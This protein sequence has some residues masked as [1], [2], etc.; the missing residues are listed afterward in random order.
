MIGSQRGREFPISAHG[1]SNGRATCV[2]GKR[3]ER[4]EKILDL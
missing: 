1:H 4:G 2:S 3:F